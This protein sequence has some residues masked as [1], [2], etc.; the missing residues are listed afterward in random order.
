MCYTLFR[1]RKANIFN[2]GSQVDN[3][4]LCCLLTQLKLVDRYDRIIIVNKLNIASTLI[5]QTNIS[6]VYAFIE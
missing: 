6:K 4:M 3:H 5:A 2:I 1:N